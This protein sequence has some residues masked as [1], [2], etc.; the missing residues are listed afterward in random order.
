MPLDDLDLQNPTKK[1][2]TQKWF[3]KNGIVLFS[4]GILV[5]LGLAIPFSNL[6]ELIDENPFFLY[7]IVVGIIPLFLSAV[8]SFF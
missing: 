3:Y 4:F 2:L 6:N 7:P 1:N 5:A 8:Y